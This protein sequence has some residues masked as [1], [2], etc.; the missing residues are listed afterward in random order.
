MPDPTHVSPNSLAGQAPMPD[1]RL[2]AHSASPEG[3]EHFD[4]A[5]H[6]LRRRATGCFARS[7]LYRNR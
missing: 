3:P 5:Q 6:K 7:R 2:H 1:R 4:Y